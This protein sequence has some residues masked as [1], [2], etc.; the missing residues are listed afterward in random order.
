LAYEL[1]ANIT[2]AK[3]AVAKLMKKEDGI[4]IQASEIRRRHG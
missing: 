4:P 3:A 2:K 1:E